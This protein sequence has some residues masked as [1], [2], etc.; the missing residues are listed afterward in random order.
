[1]A[2]WAATGIAGTLAIFAIGGPLMEAI[3]LGMPDSSYILGLV[4][5]SP[6][7]FALWVIGVAWLAAGFG[8]EVLW[9]GFLMDR[10]ERL[11][12]LRGR[13]WLV[14]AVQAVLFGLPHAYQ[15]MG[16]VVVTASVGLLLGW[17]RLRQ[18]G[19]LWAVIIAHATVDTV[20][21][22]LAYADKLGWY[23]G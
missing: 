23:T 21:M 3:G 6:A 16:G 15:G 17:I 4:T 12:G 9:R 22:S 5:E 2:G 11:A 1:M 8:E 14:L 13:A 7:M 20:M 18:R 10:L 19:N